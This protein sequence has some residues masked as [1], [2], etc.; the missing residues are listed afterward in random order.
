L[1]RHRK[2][3]ARYDYVFSTV[4]TALKAGELNDYSA[5]CIWGFH[6][7]SRM[8]HLL[9]VVLDKLEFP[10]LLSMMPKLMGDWGVRSLY[11][12]SRASG[13]PLIQSLRRELDIVVKEVVPTKDK[14]M[15]ANTVAPLVEDGRVS[16]YENIPSLNERV[17]ELCSFPFIKHDDFVDAFV[18]AVE[19]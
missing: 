15:R 14:V 10:D 1:G 6:R 3:L 13:I 17:S 18:M 19:V 12:E 5:V 7:R 11:V 9:H 4:D 8:L 16:L 2:N